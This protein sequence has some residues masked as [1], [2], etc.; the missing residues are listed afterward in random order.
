MSVFN[1]IQRYI[2]IECLLGLA[3]TL[4]V[5]LFAI[6]LVDVVE[7]LRT[8]G[9]RADIGFGGALELTLYKT[10]GLI[11]ETLPFAML[12]GSILTYSRL[13]RRSE[14]AAMR[15]A[16]VSAW[17]FLGPAML[18]AGL[19]GAIMVT[20]LD[21]LATRANE[22]FAERRDDLMNTRPV[23]ATEGVWLRQGDETGQSVISA[24]RVVGRGEALE[25]VT[26]YQFAPDL[27]VD[28][29]PGAGEEPAFTRRIDAERAVLRPGFWQLEGVIE[30]V[31]GGATTRE[32]FLAIP[33]Q[34]DSNT[35]VSRFASSKTIP[36]WDL[37][38]IIRDTRAAGLDPGQYLLKF[39]V[40]LATPV[41]MIAMSLIGGVVCLRLAR[42]GGL[43]Q[44]IASGA[45]AGF[46]LYF[47]TQIASG[48]SASGAAP[49]EAAA[50]CPP[51]TALLAVL[52]VIAFSED[53]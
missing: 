47:V 40:L 6:I 15:A 43:S 41:L 36:F 9:S 31:M 27:S 46:I 5:I 35:L 13:N 32:A 42:S 38:K 29:R 7:Q 4:G 3:L 2:F 22:A 34:L 12:I 21:P 10:P 33:T 19:V 25:G 50:W 48:L 44:L 17:R 16:G 39:H 28:G 26:I 37:P 11:Q 30:N 18:L 51:L 49:P 24:K 1:R 23:S 8:I 45:F 14:I 52:N 20:L 53:G